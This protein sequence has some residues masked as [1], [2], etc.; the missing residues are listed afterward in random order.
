MSKI[1]GLDELSP[2]DQRRVLTFCEI[3]ATGL[4]R[5]TQKELE[6]QALGQKEK[7]P[8]ASANAGWGDVPVKYDKTIK[9]G[10][11]TVHIVAP[12]PKS[13]E[14]IKKILREL[15]NVGWSIIDELAEKE[16]QALGT[17]DK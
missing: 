8:G 3:I 13:D 9:L 16:E 14:E 10:N 7:E 1:L 2:D 4:L 12:P 11:T 15:H 5:L 17:D 6:K